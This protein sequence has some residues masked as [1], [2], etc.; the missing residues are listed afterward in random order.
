MM[1]S[2]L[3]CYYMQEY[4]RKFPVIQW[5]IT[6]PVRTPDV[7]PHR[8]LQCARKQEEVPSRVLLHAQ[9]TLMGAHSQDAVPYRVRHY[10]RKH[11]EVPY[12]APFN[13]GKIVMQCLIR[14]VRENISKCPLRWLFVRENVMKWPLG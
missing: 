9:S 11:D 2:S 7:K 8:V 3:V 5:I 10:L 6:A 13:W 4:I 12:R 14:Y 1:M